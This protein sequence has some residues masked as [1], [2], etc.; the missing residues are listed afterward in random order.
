[1]RKLLVIGLVSW[2]VIAIVLLGSGGHSVLVRPGPWGI[3]LGNSVAWTGLIAFPAAQLLG[4]YHRQ[5]RAADP[6]IDIF[7]TAAW[8]ALSL[9][10]A[11]GVLGYGLSGNWAFVF[12]PEAATFIGSAEAAAF[13]TYLTIAT[14]T[15][16]LLILILYLVYRAL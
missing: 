16:P 14:V 1:M 4:L 5:N 2:V 6:R 10:G 15:L 3:P 8:G 7:Y 11:W 13:F 12:T 9:S